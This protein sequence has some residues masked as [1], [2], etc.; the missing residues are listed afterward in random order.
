MVMLLMIYHGYY[1]SFPTDSNCKFQRETVHKIISCL[2]RAT[3]QR[4]RARVVFAVYSRCDW[5]RSPSSNH[6]ALVCRWHAAF[7]PHTS[8]VMCY[9]DSTYD[10]EEL[11]R[12]M[13]SN[14]LKLNKNKTQFMWLGSRRQ[15]TKAHMQCQ[16]L[17][18]DGIKIEFCTELVCI[19]VVFYPEL[20]FAVHIRRLAGKCFYHR[21]QLRTVRWTLTIDA[22]KTLVH[23]FIT[24][25][26]NYCNSDF[27]NASAVHLYPL[28]SVLHAAACVI[29]RKRKYDYI[30]ATICD[31][32]HW[33][34]VKQRIDH[35]LCTLIYKCLHNIAPLCLRDM[36]IP[37][38]SILG[39]SSLRSAAHGDLWHQRTR[40][41]TFGPHAFAV[42]GLSTWNILPATVRDPLLT[43]G[44]FCKKCYV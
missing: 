29:V 2:W 15:I 21:W 33:L 12:W 25:R 20:T 34:P 26:V 22:A 43:Y 10:I 37:V 13:S 36:C 24:S 1:S 40:T 31:Q 32:L 18:L 8:F 14:R 27:S 17:T 4:P 11:E 7:H 41:K 3:R 38:S 5:I 23:A 35:K 9:T 39:R 44:Q 28:Q 42:L 6:P 16:T 30:S 19:G